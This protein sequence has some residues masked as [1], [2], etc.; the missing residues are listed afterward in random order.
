LA[1]LAMAAVVALAVPAAIEAILGSVEFDSGTSP[2]TLQGTPASGAEASGPVTDG[3]APPVADFIARGGTVAEA[4]AGELVLGDQPGSA[5]VMAFPVIPGDPACIGGVFVDV[6]IRQATPTE[7]GSFLA[8]A[9]DAPS[10]LDGAPV[11]AELLA[12]PEPSARAFTDGTPGRLRWDVTSAY[13]Q[14]V[15]GGTAPQGAPFVAAITAVSG[16][17]PGGGVR[18]VAVEAGADGP[19]I[20]WTGVPGCQT[21]A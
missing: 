7:L 2:E 17:A 16:V 12:T 1:L 9:W 8:T 10:L 11:P 15:T 5:V 20:S 6:T 14:F 13:R 18:V 3:A 21:T 19:A 4:R